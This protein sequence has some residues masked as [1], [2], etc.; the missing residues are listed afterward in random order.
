MSTPVQPAPGAAQPANPLA[1][2]FDIETKTCF[3]M[4]DSGFE[5]GTRAVYGKEIRLLDSNNDTTHE[6]SRI[7]GVV[8]EWDEKRI[9]QALE[10]GGIEYHLAY[11]IFND[12]VRR[13]VI[14]KGDYFVRVCW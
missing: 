8:N 5:A 3:Y 9:Q 14:P 2:S 1:E 11:L 7:D 13:G 4:S 6:Y 12:L 10:Q